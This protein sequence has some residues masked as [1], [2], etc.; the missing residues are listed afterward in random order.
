MGPFYDKWGK[1]NRVKTWWEAIPHLT[2]NKKKY[3][4]QIIEEKQKTID[5]KEAEK[6]QQWAAFSG[7]M[8][9]VKQNIQDVAEL[10]KHINPAASSELLKILLGKLTPEQLAEAQTEAEKLFLPNTNSS[11][12][13]EEQK[14]A[15]ID[16]TP[17]K[18][19][20]DKEERI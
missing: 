4:L 14:P 17:P 11:L 16:V 8:A 5:Q 13:S 3:L 19:K 2:I 20:D 15:L 9:L 12:P 1:L 6:Q 7:A 10:K 18:R